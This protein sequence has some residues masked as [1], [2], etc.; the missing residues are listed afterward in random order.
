MTRIAAV[1]PAAVVAGL[2]LESGGYF[3]R[4]WVWSS[5]VLLWLAAVV[6]VV[7]GRVELDR[8]GALYVGAAAALTV[9]TLVSVTWSITRSESVLD[10][11]RDVVYIAGA[12]VVVVGASRVSSGVLAAVA[13]ATVV[14]VVRY[15][16]SGPVDRAEGHLLS[17]PVGYANAFGALA[18]IALPLALAA[19]AR[20]ERVAVRAA[21]AASVPLFLSVLVLASSRGGAVAAVVGLAC[22]GA[23]DTRRHALGATALRLAPAAVIAVGVCVAAH[24]TGATSD[25]GLRRAAVAVGLA[26]AAAAASAPVRRPARAEPGRPFPRR[27]AAVAAV[28]GVVLAVVVSIV[29]GA[30]AERDAYWGVARHVVAVHP[31][32]GA[33][34][35]SFGPEWFAQGPVDRYGGALDAHNLYLETL[36]EL[37]PIGLVLVVLFLAVP[38]VRA[39]RD[40]VAAAA[41]VAFLVHALLDW[42][43]EMP[44]VT[45]AGVLLGGSLL[46]PQRGRELSERTRIALAAAAVALAL[47]ALVGLRSGA[48]PG[49][50]AGEP[51]AAPLRAAQGLP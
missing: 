7:G 18:A 8:T 20:A 50:A 10:A 32:L 36:A 23:L 15:L 47:A 35:G 24:L 22:L 27:A 46:L 51:A 31:A 45:L 30:G 40:A 4:A 14:G 2:A 37:G 13:L 43:W 19:A 38:L 6:L 39:R 25:L 5:V 17:W 28:A 44:A 42:D 1:L 49:G 16:I 9:W 11:R 33:G 34:A 29:G 41:Y 21:A 26:V 3:P 48:V 12:L